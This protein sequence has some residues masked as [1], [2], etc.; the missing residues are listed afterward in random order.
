MLAAVAALTAFALVNWAV[1]DALGTTWSGWRAPLAVA[2]VWFVVAVVFGVIVLQRRVRSV[3]VSP[4]EAEERFRAT[5]EE[6]IEAASHAAEQRIARMILPVA[7]GMLAA[8]EGM[9][10]ATDD[11]IEAA[12]EITDVLQERIPGGVVVNR[13]FDLALVPGRFGI[14]VV[15]V[16]FRVRKAPDGR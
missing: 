8:G 16:V 4:E 15:R 12:D 9:I 10:E 14:R 7:G 13:A 11:V 3:V 2:V 1:V 6:L 5:L